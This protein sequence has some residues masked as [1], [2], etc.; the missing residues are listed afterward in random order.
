MPGFSSETDTAPSLREL[1]SGPVVLY[2]E[3]GAITPVGPGGKKVSFLDVDWFK[4]F[5][6]DMMLSSYPAPYREAILGS[7]DASGRVDA[8]KVRCENPGK[9]L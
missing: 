5:S 1:K 6:R 3:I 8:T 9:F 2:G 4:I 7:C